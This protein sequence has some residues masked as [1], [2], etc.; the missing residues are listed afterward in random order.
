M[1]KPTSI[2]Y[3]IDK[4]AGIVYKKHHGLVTI[5]DEIS[6]IMRLFSDPEFELGMDIM[7]ELS[8]AKPNWGLKELDQF[9]AFLGA[10]VD[11]TA[12]SKWAI[13]SPGGPISHN[14]RL[15]IKLNDSLDGKVDM[16]LFKNC[17]D[18]RAWFA[19]ARAKVAITKA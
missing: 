7:C 10:L 12:K 4:S 2:S 13:I 16:R 1:T 19:E 11:K 17:E 14:A 5:E 6:I 9:R 8:E 18:A 3:K 15:F